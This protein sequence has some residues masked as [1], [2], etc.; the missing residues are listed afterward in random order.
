LKKLIVIATLILAHLGA[1]SQYENLVL[2]GGGMKGL[3]YSGAFEVLDSM[4][5]I[6]NINQVAGTSSGAMNGM[7]IS[8]GYTGK[9]LTHLN[10][11]KNFGKYSQVGIPILSGLIR[12]YR[13]YGYYKTDRFMVDLAQAMKYKGVSP[14]ITFMELHTLRSSNPKLK[15]LYITGAN[16]TD[17]KLE[18]FGHKTYPNMKI[19]DAVKISIS[20]PLYYEAIFMQPN[21]EIIDKKNAD[22]NTKVMT[23]GGVIANYPFHVFDSLVYLNNGK[24]SYYLCNKKT[25]GLKL[26]SDSSQKSMAKHVITNQKDFINAFSHLSSETLNRQKLGSQQLEQTIFINT[27]GFNP[28][29][30]RLSEKKKREIIQCGYQS[31]FNFFL[32]KG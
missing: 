4:G 31:T 26:E 16:L 22:Q 25:L 11:E 17:Q 32:E 7:L 6:N 13:K 10:L 30:K 14:D 21:G 19:I 24:N 18:V 1:Y 20:I 2:E 15:D 28:K 12:F 23:D 27:K 9:E 29:I 5:I 3:A 8:I